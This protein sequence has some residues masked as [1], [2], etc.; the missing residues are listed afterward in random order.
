VCLSVQKRIYYLC[1][2]YHKDIKLVFRYYMLHGFSARKDKKTFGMNS[3]QFH[4]TAGLIRSCNGP[5]LSASV[6]T[7]PYPQ[8]LRPGLIR[9]C[10]GP[11]LSATVTARPYPHP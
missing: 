4:V 6:T 11:A 10:N 7:R 9:N 3:T 5:A 1:Q 2:Q 8:L